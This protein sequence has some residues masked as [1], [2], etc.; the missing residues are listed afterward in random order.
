M[1][2]IGWVLG[3]FFMMKYLVIFGFP[4]Q[5]ARIDGFEPPPV[6]ACISYVYCYGDMWKSFDRGLYDFLKRYIFIPF[7]GSKSGLLRQ[8][9]GS[10]LCFAHIFHWH[11]GEWYLF[12]WCVINFLET[13]LE[14]LGMYVESTTLVQQHVFCYLS[15]GWKRRIRA[16]AAV[17]LFFMS[18]FAI[19]YFFGG[20][21]LTGDIFM[22][23]LLIDIPWQYLLLFVFLVYCAI[24][25][26]MEV[27]R[28]GL[29]KYK[30]PVYKEAT[31]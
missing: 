27:E 11:G 5:F 7:G 15:D 31:E 30:A 8:L 4:A 23:K 3:Q 28:L 22:M 18:V 17:P 1:A 9:L 10:A 29:T 6:P 12:L 26:A 14:Q 20:I 24:Q 16:V 13:S 25:N 19:F 21:E 2:A